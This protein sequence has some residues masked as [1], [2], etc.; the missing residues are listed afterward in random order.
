MTLETKLLKI[1]S[2]LL[3][4]EQ[5]KSPPVS[6]NSVFLMFGYC[7]SPGNCKHGFHLAPIPWESSNPGS[8]TR[9]A[10]M[11]VCSKYPVDQTH[12]STA[13]TE[14]SNGRLLKPCMNMM[15]FK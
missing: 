11:G 10:L 5:N 6:L 14:E 8:C 3:G 4:Y 2:K 15:N 12:E 13:C 7:S 1:M 9:Y